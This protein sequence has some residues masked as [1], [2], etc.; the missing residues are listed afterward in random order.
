MK[1]SDRVQ[2]GAIQVRAHAMQRARERCPEVRDASD[3]ELY[4]AIKRWIQNGLPLGGQTGNQSA[5]LHGQI[6]VIVTHK[7]CGIREVR[8]ILTREQ[9]LAN[10]QSP[11]LGKPG[12][13]AG[14]RRFSE[15][16]DSG[17]LGDA[18]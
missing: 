14:R 12:K 7:E 8:T 15:R 17:R 2:P 5:W 4:E 10:L 11:V 16:R 1:A 6:V 18:G 9:A 3:Q 13:G